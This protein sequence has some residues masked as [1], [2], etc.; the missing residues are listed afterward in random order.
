[1][2][3]KYGIYICAL[4]LAL[5]TVAVC[6]VLLYKQN[7]T[8]SVSLETFTSES[9]PET[10]EPEPEVNVEARLVSDDNFHRYYAFEPYQ[11]LDR[12]IISSGDN[13]RKNFDRQ[14]ENI[15]RIIASDISINFYVYICT[16][17][18]D[19]KYSQKIVPEEFSTLDFFNE[20][21]DS[22]QGAAG[23]GW[24]D[25]DT[26]E[27]RVERV[28]RT[29]HHWSA[30]G[31]YSGYVDC[32]DMMK[33]NTPQIGDPLPLNGESG[34]ITFEDVQMRGSFAAT[35][36]FR[37]YYEPFI[38]LDITLPEFSPADV[39]IDQYERYSAGKFDKGTFTDH[40]S[41]YY[42]SSGQRKYTV[43]SNATGRNLL[44]I[45]DSY[46]WWFSWLIAANFDNVY[47]YLPPWDAKNFRYHEFIAENGITDVLLTQFSDRLM[48]NYYGDS[49]FAG[50][51]TN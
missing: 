30:A 25:I 41:A 38:V 46:S 15:N 5:L 37:D 8:A 18:Q 22:I 16:R 51:R 42:N 32:I 17:M 40:Y 44:I 36:N 10:T 49:N 2:L 28:F 45:A 23:I 1:L 9:P 19:T 13:L 24:L 12:W 3:K 33:K 29:D 43:S 26:I 35:L 31:A 11:F 20:F 27:K 6:C 7:H 34:Y 21:V 50:I 48:F 47:I 39:H 14:V 4:A